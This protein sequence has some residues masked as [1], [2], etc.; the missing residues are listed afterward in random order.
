MLSLLIYSLIFYNGLYDFTPPLYIF[1]VGH[2]DLPLW[3]LIEIVVNQTAAQSHGIIYSFVYTK[4]GGAAR[5]ISFNTMRD[6]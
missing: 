3:K 6:S 5:K 2:C 4:G 1:V